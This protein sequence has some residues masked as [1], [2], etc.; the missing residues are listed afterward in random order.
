MCVAS[1][2]AKHGHKPAVLSRSVLQHWHSRLNQEL[3]KGKLRKIKLQYGPSSDV[4]DVPVWGYYHSE[5]GMA[6]IHID[7]IVNTKRR[8]INTLAHEMVHQYQDMLHLP[9]NHGAYFKRQ[10][11]RLAKHGLEI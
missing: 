8:F 11:G 7:E 1:Y 2:L 5:D 3:F 10:Q 4:F 9:V 6:T